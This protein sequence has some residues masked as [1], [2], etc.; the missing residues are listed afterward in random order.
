MQADAAGRLGLARTSGAVN[1]EAVMKHVIHALFLA[2][3]GTSSSAWSQ[4]IGP[5]EV[6]ALPV[7]TPTPVARYGAAQLQF[8]ELRVPQGKVPFPVAVMIQGGCWLEKFTD[9][10]NLARVARDL[11]T[12]GIAPRNTTTS[13]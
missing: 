11:P 5:H 10:P 6:D 3:I 9:L 12:T 8:G 13:P 7:T 4:E 2:L 1:Q